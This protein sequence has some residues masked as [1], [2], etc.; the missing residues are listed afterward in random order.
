M[1]L[2]L[3]KSCRSI[4][5]DCVGGDNRRRRDRTK[6]V[7]GFAPNACVRA[8]DSDPER[9]NQWLKGDQTIGNSAPPFSFPDFVRPSLRLRKSLWVVQTILILC[10]T[11]FP[12]SELRDRLVCTHDV[13][14]S[15][16]RTM[17]G[18]V[19]LF[20]SSPDTRSE[21]R[22]DLQLPIS[23]L[24]VFYPIDHIP[25]PDAFSPRKNFKS[26]LAYP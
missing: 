18:L 16:F 12:I 10:A 13:T 6:G 21:R 23:Q 1:R 17:S 15:A 22:F 3:G 2:E 8:G 26:S 24:K 4:M 11:P 7:L 19:T 20:V 9:A 5:V 25:P 14:H